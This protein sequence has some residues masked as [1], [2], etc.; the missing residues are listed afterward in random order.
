M[1]ITTKTI[2][3]TT[4]GRKNVKLI[5][6]QVSGKAMSAG[7]FDGNTNTNRK[8]AKLT[9]EC[10]LE[11]F[12]ELGYVFDYRIICDESNNTDEVLRL[13]QFALDVY[14]KFKKSSIWVKHE[15]IAQ[16]KPVVDKVDPAASI[17]TNTVVEL[18]PRKE[19]TTT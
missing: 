17:P 2:T 5:V 14:F 16:S 6:N 1:T 15:G 9:L 8:V 7:L 19:K 4:I 3:A 10:L 11:S 18:R 13:E 12:V